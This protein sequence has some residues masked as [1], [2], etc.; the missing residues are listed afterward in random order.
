MSTE[1]L[2]NRYD[3]LDNIINTLEILINNTNYYTDIAEDLDYIKLDAEK[4]IEPILQKKYDE[5]DKALDQ[6]Y[7]NNQF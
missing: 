6:E 3:E 7:W 1:E 4:Q 5:E 2:Q